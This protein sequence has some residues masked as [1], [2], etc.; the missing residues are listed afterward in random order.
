MDMY[1]R[2][3]STTEGR[4]SKRAVRRSLRSRVEQRST[5]H[6]SA[7][8][9][10]ELMARHATSGSHFIY[11]VFKHEKR[12]TAEGR[13]HFTRLFHECDVF[14]ALSPRFLV[15]RGLFASFASARPCRRRQ[16]SALTRHASSQS[17]CMLCGE[18]IFSTHGTRDHGRTLSRTHGRMVG[19]TRTNVRHE[20]YRLLYQR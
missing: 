12:A 17:L 10:I 15:A 11:S 4:P 9:A 14:C 2:E 13:A 18:G 19:A 1:L 5:N 6:G 16:C 3:I 7:T 20:A 8:H